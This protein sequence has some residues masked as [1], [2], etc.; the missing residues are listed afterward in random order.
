MTDNSKNTDIVRHET[1]KPVPK[2]NLHTILIWGIVIVFGLCAFISIRSRGNKATFHD[3]LYVKDVNTITRIYMANKLDQQV[4][5]VKHP[6]Q[7]GD[8]LWMVNDQFPASEPMMN[9]LLETLQD[10]RIRQMV[11]KK[12]IDNVLKQLAT[13]SVKVEI[14]QTRYRINW[15]SGR[16]RLGKHE[17]LTHTYYIGNESKDLLG[18]FAFEK[19]SKAPFIVHIP[20][21]RGFITPRFVCDASLWRSHRIVDWPVMQIES[22]QLD[23]P[24]MPEESFAIVR[25]GEGFRFEKINPPS[26][27]SGFDTLRV[28]QLLSSF[29]NLNFD[30]YVDVVPHTTT[31]TSFSSGPRTILTI[32]DT[33]GARREIQTFIKYTNPD[34]MEAI[35]DTTMYEVFDLNRLYA[36]IDSR[37][38]VLIQYYN[39]DNI[40]QPASYFLGQS[41]TIMAR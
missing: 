3:N 35:R 34:D 6:E 7:E 18:S 12:A 28:A 13:K 5:L 9:L 38:T 30:E 29:V 20:S 21:L 14:Y 22:V 39:F 23:I 2:R 16:I 10:M 31:D 11:N 26:I 19:G 40:L 33:T 36:V 24:S 41:K 37:D 17:K 4:L 25:N 8:S 1:D 27:V 15:F 32:T